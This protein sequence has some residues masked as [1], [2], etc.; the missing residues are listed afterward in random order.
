MADRLSGAV[1]KHATYV[2]GGLPVGLDSK[3][4]TIR[5]V[6]QTGTGAYTP[7]G[8]NVI[9]IDIPRT[10]GFLDTQ[11]SYLRFRIKVDSTQAKLD[12]PCYMDK[13]G[14]SWCERFEVVSNNGSVLE[15]IHD[16]NLLVNLLHKST[17]PDDYRLTSGKMLDNQGSRAERMAN[18]ASTN[19]RM[20]CCG[21]DASGIFGGNTKYLP[22]QFID[23]ALTLEFSL[24]SFSDCFVGT[25][26]GTSS[27]S[28]TVW[29]VEYVAEC[30]SFGQDFN[31][32]FEQQ[33]RTNGIDIAF[34]SYRSHHHALQTGGD[35]VIQLAQN[36]K[37]V[38][39]VY[40]VMRDKDRYRSANFE[41]LSQY[42]SGR[43]QQWQLD[44][45]G[46]LFP[47]FPV[48]LK[49]TGEA[50][51]YATNLNSFNHFRDQNGGSEITRETFAP[52]N[53]SANLQYNSGYNNTSE[54]TA[55]FYGYLLSNGRLKNAAVSGKAA[56]LENNAIAI[57]A[58]AGTMFGAG[59][60]AL[61]HSTSVFFKPS[62]LFDM[63]D[64]KLGDRFKINL[65]GTAATTDFRIDNENYSQADG[66]ETAKDGPH[67]QYLYCVGIGL[68]VVRQTA[69]AAGAGALPHY[70]T[71][72][73]CVALAKLMTPTATAAQV[74]SADAYMAA[75]FTPTTETC[76]GAYSVANWLH[77]KCYLDRVP[78]DTDYYIGQSF[79]THE[80]HEK[81]ISGMDTTNTVPLH[82]N[83]KFGNTLTANPNPPIKQGDLL[84]A[85]LHYDAV[86]RIEPDG[87]VV[88]SM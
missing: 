62:N 30:I 18:L 15:S 10:I 31:Y 26:A 13:N 8:S 9:R 60:S 80:E 17:S 70:E 45:G 43:I 79:E 55:R 67:A 32:L 78:S 37:S 59:A 61:Y 66:H 46:R 84:T 3:R 12:F 34:H 63:K 53:N 2:Q 7:D 58:A 41:S 76:T 16:Y 57:A 77:G 21:L 81:L 83:L 71:L 35:Q 56:I 74:W 38:K 33:L 29:N 4:R 65:L 72:R 24:A 5:L 49:N 48:D 64:M 1:P 51:N 88:S 28:Y 23:G 54:I 73:G 68:D 40:V 86:M 19:G 11:N 44:L 47:E 50:G 36:S 82:I 52:Y 87:S 22:C 25:P 14:M 39:G 6:P 20:F 69:T 27:G 42:K 75:E 85:F